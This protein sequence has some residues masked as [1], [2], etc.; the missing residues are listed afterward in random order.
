MQPCCLGSCARAIEIR[1]WPRLCFPGP[2]STTRAIQI[3]T[4]APQPDHGVT[5]LL[6]CTSQ[7]SW[8]PFT[9]TLTSRTQST[10]VCSLHLSAATSTGNSLWFCNVKAHST[11]S[12]PQRTALSSHCEASV[13]GEAVALVP[14]KGKHFHPS[15]TFTAQR[16]CSPSSKGLTETPAQTGVPCHSREGSWVLPFPPGS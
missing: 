14:L 7:S 8:L 6:A 11:I 1:I 13:A 3:L 5:S 15:L 10:T 2:K 9:R 12:L 16:L 4:D